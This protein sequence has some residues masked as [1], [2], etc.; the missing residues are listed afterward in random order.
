M[1]VFGTKKWALKF[2]YTRYYDLKHCYAVRKWF[3]NYF[4][5]MNFIRNKKRCKKVSE[6]AEHD[7]ELENIIYMI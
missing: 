1:V 2:F 7:N 4:I 5:Q 6:R 3:E